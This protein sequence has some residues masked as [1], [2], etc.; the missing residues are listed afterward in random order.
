VLGYP[1]AMN[2]RAA[3]AGAEANK[4][5]VRRLW[6]TLYTKNWDE[7]ATL[8][9]DDA[10]YEDVPTPDPGAHGPANI[11]TRLRIGLD[12][13]ERF[14]H[15]AHRMVAEGDSVI[16]EHT[17][18]W[19][20]HT[21]EVMRNPFVSV[22]EVRGGKIALWRDYWDVATMMNAV[23]KWWVEQIMQRRAEEFGG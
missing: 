16:F 23:P 18:V 2:T 7:L 13:I 6:A 11:V 9:T 19:H 14:E 3:S 4:A 20:F 21:G 12:P 5:V 22:H 10:F 15:H 8:F 1:T 17:E